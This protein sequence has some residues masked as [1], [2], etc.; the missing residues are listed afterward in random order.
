MIHDVYVVGPAYSGSTLLGNALNGHPE[1][2]HAGEISR[3]P[4]FG[5]GPEAHECMLCRVAGRRCPVW[6]PELL[7]SVERGDAIDAL[8]VIRAATGSPVVVDSSK[9][10]DWL[11]LAVAGS[12][13][14]GRSIRVLLT[15]RN[16]FGFAASVRRTDGREAW[17][18]ANL[19]R[20]TV[21][22]AMRLLGGLALP[23]MIVRYE[24]FAFEPEPLLRRIC[25][26]LS[27][28]WTDGLMRFWERDTHA[29]GGNPHAYVWYP[30]YTERVDY[31]SE[32]AADRAIATSF[33][34]R[35]FG[36]WADDRWRSELGPGQLDEILQTP[37]LTT[38]ANLAGY[39][40]RALLD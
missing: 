39:N 4:A 16:P 22:D 6:T 24:D 29:L 17:E 15:L 35:S 20:D 25:D 11:R 27:L 30:D 37:L 34:E 32:F 23:Y 10:V 40:L 1:V 2:F 33:R 12:R 28:E 9:Y 14:L 36:G 31:S 5:Y 13:G 3:L 8:P 38:V 26:F 19:W 7:D 18:A 21:F